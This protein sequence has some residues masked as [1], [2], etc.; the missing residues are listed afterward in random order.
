MTKYFVFFCLIFILSFNIYCKVGYVNMVVVMSFHPLM[1]N[2]NITMDRFYKDIKA[3]SVK[4]YQNKLQQIKKNV[5]LELKKANEKNKKLLYLI[6]KQTTRLDEAKRFRFQAMIKARGDY[7]NRIKG[8]KP[9]EFPKVEFTEEEKDKKKKENIKLTVPKDIDK[10]EISPEVKA[11]YFAEYRKQSNMIENT[12]KKRVQEV[13]KKISELRNKVERSFEYAYRDLLL[14]KQDSRKLIEQIRGDLKKTIAR[15]AKTKKVDLV[16]NSSGEFMKN[17][18]PD[19]NTVFNKKNYYDYEKEMM[20]IMNDYNKILSTFEDNHP[21]SKKSQIQGKSMKKGN[22]KKHTGSDDEHQYLEYENWFDNLEKWYL[23][24]VKEYKKIEFNNQLFLS[25]GTDI[26]VDVI[27]ELLGN[28]K[29]NPVL[30]N[31]IVN[32]IEVKSQHSE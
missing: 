8:I 1:S 16:L 11:S 29:I 15:V 6:R 27:K 17:F 32:Y 20:G 31:D 12:F 26:T 25:G 21:L 2:Y 19:Q 10:K 5:S 14:D 23:K 18:I 30:I 7:E 24:S 22:L 28:Y 13:E 4:D 9:Y 3:E